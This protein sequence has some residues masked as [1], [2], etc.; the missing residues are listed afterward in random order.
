MKHLIILT[1]C[2]MLVT[3]HARSQSKKELSAARVKSST[4]YSTKT[5]NGKTI[6]YKSAYEEYDKKGYPIL[7]AQYDE[8]GN[9]EEKENYTYDKFQRVVMKTIVDV[10][11]N[12]TE[13]KTYTYNAYDKVSTESEYAADGKL[14]KKTAYTYNAD[15]NPILETTTDASNK[16]VKKVTYTYNNK[17]LKT[18]KHTQNI[19]KNTEA[20]KKWE[21]TFY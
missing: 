17:K 7:K 1:I 11:N 5:E 2:L 21:Y 4:E 8:A 16:V 12:T 18:G 3:E 14:L 9:L 15:G 10:K 13:R 19:N 6:T 20:L